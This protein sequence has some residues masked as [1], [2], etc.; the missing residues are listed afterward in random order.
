MPDYLEELFYLVRAVAPSQKVF[1]LQLGFLREKLIQVLLNNLIIKPTTLNLIDLT[2]SLTDI[3]EQESKLIVLQKPLL[4]KI[5][6]LIKKPNLILEGH[7]R[8]NNQACKHFHCIDDTRAV[9]VPDFEGADIGAE[10]LHVLAG[11]D[12]EIFAD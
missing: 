12:C 10:D 7:L 8:E 6:N 11:A 9:G 3:H 1:I 4:I 2:R 5:K